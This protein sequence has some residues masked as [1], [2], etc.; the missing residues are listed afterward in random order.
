MEH[1]LRR[2]FWGRVWKWV[3][4]SKKDLQL[5]LQESS[6]PTDQLLMD[7]RY[8][9][10]VLCFFCSSMSLLIFDWSY[11]LNHIPISLQTCPLISSN[12]QFLASYPA[13][14]SSYNHSSHFK[15]Q[16]FLVISNFVPDFFILF[17]DCQWGKSCW[18]SIHCGTA[19]PQ[20]F[21]W[22]RAAP[23]IARGP[24]SAP[25]GAWRGVEAAELCR[26]QPVVWL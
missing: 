11:Q 23:A 12:L 9:R 1:L 5:I 6:I 13:I 14:F 8:S 18:A 7:F 25:G 4:V 15:S 24:H 19:R 21:W 2:T 22:G 3:N 20:R 10:F 16:H 17:L 26:L